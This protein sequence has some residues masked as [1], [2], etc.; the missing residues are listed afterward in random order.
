VK[1]STLIGL[2]LIAWGVLSHFDKATPSPAP[3][4]DRPAD[5]LVTAVQPVVTILKGHTDDGGKLAAFYLAVAD[6]IGRDQGKVIQNTAVL[7][8]LNRRAGLL[9]FQRTGIEGKYP[10]LAEAID[11]VL[12]DRV[13]LDNVAFDDAKQTAAIEAFKAIAWACNG[14]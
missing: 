2:L 10:G 6:V 14:G 4:P 9:T 7:R 1:A 8:E 12:A 11:K 3:S 13:G 5:A